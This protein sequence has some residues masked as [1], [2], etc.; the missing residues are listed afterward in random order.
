MNM[1]LT[2]PSFPRTREPS[3]IDYM[4]SKALYPRVRGDDEQF[5][6]SLLAASVR[7]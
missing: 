1:A 6:F 2:E 3:G 4:H 7:T 5:L